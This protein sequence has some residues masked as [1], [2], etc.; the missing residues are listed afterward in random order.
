MLQLDLPTEF[1]L[2]NEPNGWTLGRFMT[3]TQTKNGTCCCPQQ[4]C[5]HSDVILPAFWYWHVFLSHTSV[6]LHK[7]TYRNLY[8][9]FTTYIKSYMYYLYLYI[10]KYITVHLFADLY[11]HTWRADKY[12]TSIPT[13]VPQTFFQRLSREFHRVSGICWPCVILPRLARR[14]CENPRG[15]NSFRGKNGILHG[16][17]LGAGLEGLAFGRERDFEMLWKVTF[18]KWN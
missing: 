6:I 9:D 10:Q 12:L 15:E 5:L 8:I 13:A 18:H 14:I 1:R 3:E 7:Y 17:G 16:L 11:V 4:K 2:R